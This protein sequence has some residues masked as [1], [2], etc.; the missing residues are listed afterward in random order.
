MDM[1]D[2]DALFAD[3]EE[4]TNPMSSIDKMFPAPGGGN[5]SDLVPITALARNDV[6]EEVELPDTVVADIQNVICAFHLQAEV[7]LKQINFRLRTAEYNPRKCQAVVFRVRDPTVTAMIYHGGR[8]TIAG[9]KSEADGFR[10]AKKIAKTMQKIG[11]AEAVVSN[12]KVENIIAKVDME[13]PVRL[14]QLAYD[15]KAY[16]TYEPELFPGCVYRMFE[17]KVSLLIFVTGKV[18]MSGAKSNEDVDAALRGIYPIL[19][20]LQA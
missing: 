10:A 1:D 5:G 2:F 13:F 16:A 8:V 12:F 9:A 11:Y 14:E 20:K 15:Y 3:D 6:L 17:P 18:T 7:D 4:M 19:F